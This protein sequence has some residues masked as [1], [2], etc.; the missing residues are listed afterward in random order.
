MWQA[1][2]WISQCHV[3]ME[4]KGEGM[5]VIHKKTPKITVYCAGGW[6]H[7]H[8]DRKAIPRSPHYLAQFAFKYWV[9]PWDFPWDY[10]CPWGFP[11]KNTGVGCHFLLQGIVPTLGSNPGLLHC[12]WIL[13]CLSHQGSPGPWGDFTNPM[14]FVCKTP[15][16]CCAFSRDSREFMQISKQCASPK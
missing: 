16:T 13:Y 11:G 7:R 14:K 3:I 5:L 10:L 1:G 15:Y 12:K 8:S 4:E 6:Q 9:L 2:E